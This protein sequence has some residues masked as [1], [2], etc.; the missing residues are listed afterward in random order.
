MTKGVGDSG[1]SIFVASLI[2]KVDKGEL[3]HEDVEIEVRL[4]GLEAPKS[5]QGGALGGIR[6]ALLYGEQIAIADGWKYATN[7][8]RNHVSFSVTEG[9]TSESGKASGKFCIYLTLC[10][11]AA[12]RRA[13]KRRADGPRGHCLTLA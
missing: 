13:E 6:A 8:N 2:D 11:E 5:K 4:V 3:T 12:H 7:L 1:F 9:F 10:M